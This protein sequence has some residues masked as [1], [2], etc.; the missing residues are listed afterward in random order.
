MKKSSEERNERMYKNGKSKW[1]RKVLEAGGSKRINLRDGPRLDQPNPIKVEMWRVAGR[2]DAE[3]A[4]RNNRT[5]KAGG[6]RNLVSYCFIVL[7]SWCL[8]LIPFFPR[9]VWMY[10]YFVFFFFYLVL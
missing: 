7:V 8:N 2:K 4:K 9:V 10:L 3:D 1:L 5:V 6:C